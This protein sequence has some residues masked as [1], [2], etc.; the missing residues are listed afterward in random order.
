MQLYYMR[1][2]GNS[3][4]SAS[5]VLMTVA[6]MYKFVLVLTGAGILL[7]GGRSLKGYFRGYGL[8]YLFGLLLNIAVVAALLLIMLSPGIIKAVL[9]KME[10]LLIFL[11]IWKRSS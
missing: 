9:I 8:L 1:K 5:V 7:F 6:V 3:L 10:K 11:R 2:D 4:S